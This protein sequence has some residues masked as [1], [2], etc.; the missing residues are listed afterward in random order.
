MSSRFS[1]GG[2]F[3]CLGHDK[4]VFFYFCRQ[5]MQVVDW[6]AAQHI[7]M[8]LRS[9]APSNYW[10]QYSV[11]DDGAEKSSAN[12]KWAAQELMEECYRVGIFD[13]QRIRGRGAWFDNG[14]CVLHL[15]DRAIIDGKEY[16]PC[17]IP[18]KYIYE[19]GHALKAE[20]SS[21]LSNKD[22]NRFYELVAMLPWDRAISAR[23]L[24]GWCVCA[25]IG[26]VLTWRPHIWTIGRRGTGKTWCMNNI[27]GQVL[28]E[29][30]LSVQSDT[31]EAGIRQELGLDSLPVVFDE[32]EG[33]DPRSI[34]RLQSVL[35]LVRQ[36][37]SETGGR[38]VKGSANGKSV[39]YNIRSCFGFSSINSS[40]MQESDN[41]RVTVLELNQDKKHHEFADIVAAQEALFVAGY[42]ESFY[43]RA[44]KM[45]PIIRENAKIFARAI[46]AVLGEQRAGDQLGALLAGAYSLH[47]QKLLTPEKAREW[48]K[49]Q[50]WSY[51]RTEV[52][53]QSDEA[54]LLHFLLSQTIKFRPTN[55][56]V[57]S[58]IPIGV[59]IDSVMAQDP[60]N[61]DV[62]Y[63]TAYNSLLYAGIKVENGEVIVSNTSP[64]IKRLLSNTPWALN[65]YRVLRRLPGARASE[66]PVSFGHRGSEA[67][68]TIFPVQSV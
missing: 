36:S 52:Q 11:T 39:Y 58:D 47:S 54:N 27:V 49:E 67:R 68:A 61:N 48:V 13:R 10:R 32:A 18:S 6:T 45:A 65:H 37:S 4:G 19:A 59:L 23:L 3:R 43:A 34:A 44:I 40:L 57:P 1:S 60:A 33:N 5:S 53:A 56:G 25:H 14:K 55:S 20:L 24:A 29:N 35:G 26:G 9:L 42:V 30:V 2:H 15:G 17:D 16:A 8:N 46:A 62:P 28:G 51:E 12:Y 21:P 63:G 50:D 38:I 66:K 7:E 22:A 31:S 64:F 41:S